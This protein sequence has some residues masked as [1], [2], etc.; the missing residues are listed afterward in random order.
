[1][2]T[3]DRL[4]NPGHRDEDNPGLAQRAGRIA[5][6]AART[7]FSLSKR[8]PGVEAAERGFHQVERQLLGELRRRLDE[9]DDPYLVALSAASTNSG[10]DGRTGESSTF[11]AKDAIAVVGRPEPLRAAMAEL[12]NRSIGFGRDQARD[13]LFA[14]ILRQLTPDE[15]R[16][17][18]ALSDG[19]PY[20]LIDVVERNP[21]GG[22]GRTVLR[23]AS[24]VGKAAG[25]SLLDEVPSY[26]T[27]L[28][29]IGL[30]EADEEVDSLTTQYEILMTD[31]VVRRAE[32]SVKRAKFVR[33]TVRISHLGAGFWAACDPTG[34][35]LA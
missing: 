11:P 28:I 21:L 1:L 29:A 3:Q 23:N 9:V 33:R 35:P 5:G 2:G 25:V 4:I 12:L 19:A 24:T 16:I 14:V 26:V 32:G 8:L 7:G 30:A 22:T 17:L 27:R 34:G 6:W 20:P 18:S 31:D 10:S 13:Y 15:A